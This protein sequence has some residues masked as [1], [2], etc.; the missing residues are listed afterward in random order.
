[1][2]GH[3]ILFHQALSE[4]LNLDDDIFNKLDAN[5]R[6]EFVSA[7][8]N[9]TRLQAKALN[10]KEIERYKKIRLQVVPGI[11]PNN[12]YKF[13]K[14]DV[15]IPKIKIQMR[16]DMER[17]IEHIQQKKSKNDDGKG[18]SYKLSDLLITELP[19]LTMLTEKDTLIIDECPIT[20][21]RNCSKRVLN[22]V[23]TN[24]D[25]N[26]LEGGPEEVRDKYVCFKNNL[27]SLKGSP[28]KVGNFICSINSLKTLEGG[29]IEVDHWY[30]CSDNQLISLKGAPKVLKVLKC[31][32]NKLHSLKDGPEIITDVL[33]IGGNNI[34]DTQNVPVILFG[35]LKELH[36]IKMGDSRV[37]GLLSLPLK[38]VDDFID[39]LNR[40]IDEYINQHP[41][42]T[43][44]RS[45]E[46]SFF[47]KFNE[48]T[49]RL[50]QKLN[51][52]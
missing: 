34:T 10:P 35:G 21:L 39:S 37:G 16:N 8:P 22:F 52:N 51:I 25:L 20:S 28:K 7:G 26:N 42:Y 48:L 33:D 36:Y 32:Y 19:D 2:L 17:A 44:D 14:F 49:N 1:M 43:I 31:A 6:N 9:L 30:D 47:P 13:N 5:L 46:E 41:E 4:S 18:R 45:V 50:R 27:E 40:K 29:P 23:V 38:I 11:L 24:C 3:G 12:L 15:D